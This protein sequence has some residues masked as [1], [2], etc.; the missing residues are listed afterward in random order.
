MLDG[1]AGDVEKGRDLV[2]RA[3]AERDTDP[4]IRPLAVD[5]SF[6][7]PLFLQSAIE[8]ALYARLSGNAPEGAAKEWAGRSILDMGAAMLQA[9]G[10]RIISWNRDRLASQIMANTHDLDFPVR[11]CRPATAYRSTHIWPR[12]SGVKQ[13]ARAPERRRFRTQHGGQVV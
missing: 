11:P 1:A 6:S 2:I 12:S 3:L 9:R 10:E 7:N 4:T 8:G 13:I 5:G